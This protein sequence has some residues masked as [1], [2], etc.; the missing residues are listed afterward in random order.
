MKTRSLIIFELDN[1]LFTCCTIYTSLTIFRKKSSS[2]CSKGQKD[3]CGARKVF[4]DDSKK[5]ES[6]EKEEGGSVDDE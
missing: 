4:N 5:H 6:M 1:E 2:F 3:R